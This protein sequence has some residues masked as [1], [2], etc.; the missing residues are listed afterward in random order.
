MIILFIQTKPINDDDGGRGI[1]PTTTVQY[2]AIVL[3]VCM[4][5][6][7]FHMVTKYFQ[8]AHMI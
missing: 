7:A 8:S 3:L 1:I 4:T 6:P 2:H 5:F